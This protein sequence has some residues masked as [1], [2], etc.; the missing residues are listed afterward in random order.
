MIETKQ[1][2]A[3][4]KQ[5]QIGFGGPLALDQAHQCLAECYGVIGSLVME[6]DALLKK[7]PSQDSGKWS[8]AR[9]WRSWMKSTGDY[10]AGQGAIMPLFIDKNGLY[11]KVRMFNE[12]DAHELFT[13][14]WVGTDSSGNRYSWARKADKGQ[15]ILDKGQRFYAMQQ[16]QRWMIERGIAHINPRE[17]EF[18]SL[19]AQADGMAG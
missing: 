9:L 19:L 14:H 7:L 10:M 16:H 12:N 5:C 8:M 11:K 4:M 18:A 17:S 15:I 1:A 6:R 2:E 13:S 3:L